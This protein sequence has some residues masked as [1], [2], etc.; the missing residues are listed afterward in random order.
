MIRLH[1]DYNRG[2]C[3]RILEK[4]AETNAESFDGYGT[5]TWCEK[6][7]DLI[8]EKCKAPEA[9]V[10][11]LPGATQA[12]FIVHAAA[13][14]PIQSVICPESGHVYAHEAGSIENT[15]HKLVPLPSADGTITAEQIRK[16]VKAYYDDG[17]PNYICEPKM[18]YIS[19]PTEWGTLYSEQD[20]KDIR[21]VCDEYGMYLFVDGARLGYGL[22]SVKNDLTLEKLAE[23]TD[24]FY[25][26]GTKCGAL[27]GEA[28]VITNAGLAR[29]FSTYMKQNGAVLAKGW[30]LGLQFFT[31]L[32]DD[33]YEKMT[34]QADAY[35]MEI[36]EAFKEKGIPEFV[37]SYTNQQFVILTDE[38]AQKL[39]KEYTFEQERVL[40]DGR[41][42]VRF[43]T[44]WATTEAEKDQ[45]IGDIRAL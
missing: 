4:L 12:N 42:V 22:G 6:A 5:D 38:Q 26:G 39:A 1:N 11:F 31:L 8:R 34:A 25:I 16:A 24:V 35:A 2:A 21:K 28:L 43:C 7:A 36:K 27:F 17:E 33:T 41:K 30:L 29:K 18:V 45:L 13:L 40:E 32:E 9:A 23:L 19:F 14:S 44:S 37:D 10:H 20:L 3:T 15:G